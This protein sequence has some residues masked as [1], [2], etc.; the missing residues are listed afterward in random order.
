MTR[1]SE[2][3]ERSAR[4]AMSTQRADGSFPAG[5]NGPYRDPETPVRN[6]AHWAV[7]LSHVHSL[8]ASRDL[9]DGVRRAVG[10]LLST[11]ARP[12]GRG[13]VCRT[14]PRKNACNGLI[15]QA[16][17]IEALATTGLA[18]GERGWVDAAAEVFL[19]HPFD[20][21]RRLWRMVEPNG[22]DLGFD[23]TFNHQVWFAAAS[24]L[25]A[26]SDDVVRQ[27]VLA[28]LDATRSRHLRTARSGRIRHALWF[29]RR[30]LVRHPVRSRRV[31]WEL[32]VKE[33][34]YQSFNLYA[35]ALLQRQFPDHELWAARPFQRS[36][37]YLDSREYEQG[38]IT[39]RFGFQYNPPGFEVPFA[40]EVFRGA[41]PQWIGGW[42]ERQLAFGWDPQTGLTS[43][44]APDP[45]TAAARFYEATRLSDLSVDLG[46]AGR[47][48]PSTPQPPA[49]AAPRP[50]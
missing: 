22:R 36:L 7:L 5:H 21:Q 41:G 3:L 9:E 35:L 13:F 6:T 18:H 24:G 28:F 49:T 2:L 44:N 15:G 27:R 26:D 8:T 43:R 33:I 29:N 4:A 37:D 19:A 16:W 12:D 50:A 1:L 42:V 25:L 48:R 39:N 45:W 47:S 40:L 14:N 10:Y 17:A 38:I 31:R 20:P 30:N 34:G 23:P 11:A 32:P 46:V